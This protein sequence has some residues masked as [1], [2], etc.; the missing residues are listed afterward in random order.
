VHSVNGDE[1]FGEGV[2][3]VIVVDSGPR[4]ATDDFTRL[5]NAA[6]HPR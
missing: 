3:D 1:F 2:G 4:Y 5:R 6:E